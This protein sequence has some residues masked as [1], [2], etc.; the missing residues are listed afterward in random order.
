MDTHPPTDQH[1]NL[2]KGIACGIGAGALWGLV[3]LAPELIRNFT[4]MEMAGGRYVLYGLFAAAMVAPRWRVLSHTVSLHTWWTLTWLSFA[5]NT[6]YYIL[7][8][9]AVKNGGITTTTL[10]IGFLPVLVTLV[11]SRDKNAVPLRQLMPSLMLCLA[12]AGCI[13]WQALHAHV[14]SVARAPLFGLLCALAA[15][16]S[17]TLYAVGNSRAL[18]RQRHFSAHDWNLLTGLATGAQNVVLLPLALLLDTT[19]HGLDQWRNFALVSTGVALLAS[20]AGNALWNRM[21]QLLPLTLVGQ[22]ILSETLF[23][24]C[25]GFIWEQRLP[26]GTETLA[27]GCVVLSVLLCVHAHRKPATRALTNSAA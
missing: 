2:G 10:V 17:W 24:L 26:T 1:H 25:Y 15:L 23:S 22:M 5:G 21:N 3:F 14:H 9:S 4:P 18:V 8:S 20:I 7:L 11:G 12:G 19:P 27:F 13:G 16:G 6:A